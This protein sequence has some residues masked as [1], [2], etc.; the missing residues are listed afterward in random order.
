ML[1]RSRLGTTGYAITRIGLGAWAIGGGGWQGGWGPQDDRESID[2][3]TRAVSLGINWIDTAPAYGL[4]HAEEIV[5]RALRRM[6]PADRPYVFTKC[7]LVW[8][9]DAT[10]VEN[11]LAPESIRRECE[12]S[13]RRLRVDALDLLQV[14]WPATDGTP[15]E[16][17]WATLVDLVTE[18][19]ARALGVSNFEVD[20]LERCEA[21]R[22]IDT[23]QPELNLIRRTAAASTIPW[24]RTHR[25]GVIVYS[26][27]RSG[28][29][30][31]RFTAARVDALPSDD[32]R[33]QDA[34]YRPP[35]LAANLRFADR[36]AGIA[37]EVGSSTATMAITW[38]L[39]WPGVDGAIVGARRPEQLEDWIEAAEREV[40]AEELE[41][42]A[43]A[44][45]A[46]GVG[47][48]PLRPPGSRD[49]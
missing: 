21:I 19:K 11:V 34:D 37:A 8:R 35:R 7:G 44:L 24:A 41:A 18:G 10:T 15:I 30:T 48:G 31:G 1:P 39:A 20:L 32:W 5:G 29:L 9:P 45:E 33:R 3:I 47:E 12:D 4:G 6:P 40:S 23:F 26:P 14:H 13:L 22:H 27:M 25:T 17:S 2:A 46:E 16:E 43:S 36:L 38:A 49:G 42:I 28:L